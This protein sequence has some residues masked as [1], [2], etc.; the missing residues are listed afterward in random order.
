M[1]K[2][3]MMIVVLGLNGGAYAAEDAVKTLAAQAPEAAKVSVPAVSPA[4]TVLAE[5]SPLQQ[6]YAQREALFMKGSPVTVGSLNRGGNMFGVRHADLVSLGKDGE[7]K[8]ADAYLSVLEQSY[9]NEA[10]VYGISVKLN[11][12]FYYEADYVPGD[13]VALNTLR[14]NVSPHNRG[15]A[16]LAV[17]EVNYN[18]PRL[19]IVKF[20]E[21][22][23]SHHGEKEYTSYGLLDPRN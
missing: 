21:K 18:G 5:A 9:G 13:Y 12:E 20:T 17:V 4:E 10:T 1:K 6:D 2:V 8:H 15:V 3:M 7:L 22:Y 23:I 16:G 11:S 14:M 19:L